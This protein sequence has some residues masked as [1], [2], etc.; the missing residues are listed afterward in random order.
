M[1]EFPC[2]SP[3]QFQHQIPEKSTD[4]P[5]PGPH[6]KSMFTTEET[7]K[8][9][10]TLLKAFC[11]SPPLRKVITSITAGENIKL[12]KL[13]CTLC[14][15]SVLCTAL[16]QGWHE[17]KQDRYQHV[18]KAVPQLSHSVQQ[19]RITACC[20]W[21]WTPV[22]PDFTHKYSLSTATGLLHYSSR[23]FV[24]CV[25]YS[26]TWGSSVCILSF[27]IFVFI[28]IYFLP[29]FFLFFLSF[30]FDTLIFPWSVIKFLVFSSVTL[31]IFYNTWNPGLFRS[32]FSNLYNPV[33]LFKEHKDQSDLE[34]ISMCTNGNKSMNK[35]EQ[36]KVKDG[37]WKEERALVLSIHLFYLYIC[38][39]CTSVMFNS[40][41]GFRREFSCSFT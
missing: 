11:S 19:N 40:L 22:N 35:L 3:F 20:T 9:C 17:N 16:C 41:T 37:S 31:I 12:A 13:I 2:F 34:I 10:R 14:S 5:A 30:Y 28:F 1:C 32:D 4:N 29:H 8:K 24:D 26:K 15:G 21:D 38:F 23:S 36:K 39:I 18:G 27:C 6:R 25:H 7:W 33:A